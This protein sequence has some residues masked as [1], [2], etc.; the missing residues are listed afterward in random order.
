MY[1][2]EPLVRDD[3]GC[4]LEALAWC[5]RLK[6]LDLSMEFFEADEGGEALNWPFPDASAFAKLSSLTKLA[7]AT[8]S[9][10][11]EPYTLA[12]MVLALTS[13]T[14]LV[15]LSLDPPQAYG[16]VVPAALGQFKGL[17]ELAL[18]HLGP[19]VFEAGCLDLPSLQGL[20]F[21]C[22]DLGDAQVLPGITALQ[23]LTR[24]EFYGI[25]GSCFFDPDIAQLPRL[26]HMVVRQYSHREELI[27]LPAD[28]GLLSSSLLHL[29][30]SGLTQFPVAMTQLVALKSLKASEN[31]C[32]ELPA[33]ITALSRLTELT[34]GR[35]MSKKDPMQLHVKRSLDVR[36][37][38]DLSGFPV[39]RELTLE[40][41]EIRLCPSLLGALQHASLVNLCFCIAHPA[42]ECALMV[43]QLR[44][45]L[46]RLGRGA[47]VRSSTA[48]P[49]CVY[50]LRKARG[51]APC[52][53]FAA[54]LEACGQ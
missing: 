5:P 14:A 48:D 13:L 20:P 52:Q 24:V 3:L 42:F 31:K 30:V 51:R 46:R 35:L 26:H 34:L 32:S 49:R 36:A 7:L 6:A 27:R 19:C 23:S 39:L 45:E 16:A 53:K 54:A 29:E 17:R 8:S 33:G 40:F 2:A 18:R 25:L 50:A 22:C 15:E 10:D 44:H 47:V 41:C 9:K 12:D 43:L 21:G 28:M 4:L 11:V 1:L 38:G 37:L